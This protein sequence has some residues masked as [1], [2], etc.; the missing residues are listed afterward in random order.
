MNDFP[1]ASTLQRFGQFAFHAMGHVAMAG[2]DALLMLTWA[3]MVPVFRWCVY[4]DDL[5]HGRLTLK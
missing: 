4:L 5:Y 1:K 3:L 2:L